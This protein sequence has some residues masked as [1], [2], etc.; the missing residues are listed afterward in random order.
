MRKPKA[1]RVIKLAVSILAAAIMMFPFFMVI[2][3]SFK[4][5]IE[6]AQNP[7]GFSGFVGFDN[8]VR[9]FSTMDYFRAVGNSLIVTVFSLLVIIVFASMLGY[10]LQRWNWKINKIIFLVLVSAMIIPF[11][12]LMIPLVSIYG[13][14]GILNSMPILIY[15]YLGFGLPLSTFMYHG[16]VKGI[17]RELEEAAIIDGCTKL[18]VFWKVVFPN[19]APVTVTIMILNLLWIWN[20]FL[21]PSLVLIHD[22]QRTLPLSTFYFFGTYTAEFGL[23][24]A[25]LIM[26][27]IPLLIVYLVLQ[28]RII[29]GVVDGAIK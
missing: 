21:L 26:A 1:S 2:L 23:G 25:A 5:R 20:D 17:P 11:Q 6:I 7:L 27:I 14:M 15:F 28:K 18:G 3:N 9:A 16:F 10:F 19:L 24:M 4:A 13:N 8:F 12:A 22:Y 29:K